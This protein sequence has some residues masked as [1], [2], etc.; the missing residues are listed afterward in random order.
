MEVRSL[1]L[2]E[3]STF[4][5]EPTGN[6]PQDFCHICIDTVIVNHLAQFNV[7]TNNDKVL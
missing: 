5:Q 1:F 2:H 3:E 6:N 4:I 7:G